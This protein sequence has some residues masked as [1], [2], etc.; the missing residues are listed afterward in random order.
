MRPNEE[1]TMDAEHDID[2]DTPLPPMPM[3]DRDAVVDD[4]IRRS[5]GEPL[6][7]NDEADRPGDHGD[8]PGAAADVP[9]AAWLDDR[10]DPRLT[11]AE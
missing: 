3:R 1:A 6:P 5:E 8:R 11:E 7:T 2:R 4:E 9:D 10:I